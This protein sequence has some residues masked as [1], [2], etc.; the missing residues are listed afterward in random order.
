MRYFYSFL[1][2]NDYHV[3]QISLGT[4]FLFKVLFVCNLYC[5]V[6]KIFHNYFLFLETS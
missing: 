6:V 5:Q 1:N 4:F 2:D 3:L